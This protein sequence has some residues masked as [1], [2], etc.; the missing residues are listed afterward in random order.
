MSSFDDTSWMPAGLVDVVSVAD[1][2][3]FDVMQSIRAS[4]SRRSTGAEL[5][6]LVYDSV[7]EEPVG[8]RSG[9]SDRHLSFQGSQVSVEVSVAPERR[10]VLGQL[11]PALPGEVEVRHGSGSYVLDIDEY[12]RFFADDVPRGP[13]SFRCRGEDGAS[14]VVAVTDW[15]VF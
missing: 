7:L 13:V 15:I 11:V 4:F 9:P 5:A 8:V 2:V 10:R 1:P 6:E 3:P 14:A 12:G